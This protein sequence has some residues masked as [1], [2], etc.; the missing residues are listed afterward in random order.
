MNV[1]RSRSS[2]RDF[3]GD[4]TTAARE[5]AEQAL[6]H[7]VGD[8]TEQAYRRSSALERRRELMQQ[9]ADY[10]DGKPAAANVINMSER[11]RA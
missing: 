1:R 5:V 9:W 4:E 11:I 2:F 3:C 6:A 10:L 7:K 8:A